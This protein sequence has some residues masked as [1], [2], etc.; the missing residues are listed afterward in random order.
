MAY[1]FFFHTWLNAVNESSLPIPFPAL[2]IVKDIGWSIA[3]KYFYLSFG[4]CSLNRCLAS[5][6]CILS[7]LIRSES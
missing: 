1:V 5:E 3:V 2:G 4:S 7:G 6:M